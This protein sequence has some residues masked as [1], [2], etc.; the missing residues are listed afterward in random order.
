[1]ETLLGT[2]WHHLPAEKVEELLETSMTKGLDLFTVQER[3]EHFGPNVLSSKKGHGPVVRFLLQFSQPLVI[4]LL[5][6]GIV[7]GFIVEWSDAS[8][9]LAVVLVNAIIGFVQESRAV[10]AIEA[11]ARTMTTTTTVLRSGEVRSLSSE[12]LVPGDIVVLQS[13]DRVPADLRLFQLRELRVDE[14]VLTGESIPLEKDVGV[15]EHSA[16][17]A[18][19]RNMAYASTLVTFGQGRGIVVATGNRT[20]MGRISQLISTVQSL[21]TPLTQRI[22][23]FSRILLFAILG[24]GVLT[25][26]A[27][28]LH[29]ER[30][31]DMFMAAV[32]LT[33]GSVPEG[34]PA[35]VTIILAVGVSR[36]AARK[37]IIRRLPAVET[38]GSTTVICSDKTGT[39]TENQMT[40]MEILAGDSLYTVTGSGYDPAGNVTAGGQAV[41]PDAAPALMECLR[42]GLLC[43]DSR[44]VHSGDR[45]SVEGDPT[46]GALIVSAAKGGLRLEAESVTLPR[47]D[48]IPFESEY[49]YMATLHGTGDGPPILYAK[50]SVESVVAR[51]DDCLHSRGDFAALDRAKVRRDAEAMARQ[52]LRV[53]AFARRELP[54]GQTSLSRE[55]LS[56]GLT[57]LGLQGMIDPPRQEAVQAVRACQKAGIQV[58][59]ITGD[60]A[61]TASAIAQKIGLYLNPGTCSPDCHVLTAKDLAEISDT[62]L[63]QTVHDTEVFARV[64]P[65]QKLRLVRALQSR[66]EIVAMTGDGVNDA[67]ALKQADIGV[68]MGITGTEVA[69]ESADMILTDDNFASIEAAVEE[70]RCVFD[71]LTKFIAWALPTNIGQGLVILTAVLAGVPL[72]ILPVQSL[73]INMTTAGSLGLMLAFEPKEGGIMERPPRDPGS[74]ILSRDLLLQVLLVGFILLCSAFGLFELEEWSGAS[75]AEARTVSVNVFAAVSS[76]Y[77]LNCRSL[78]RPSFRVNPFRNAW[79]LLGIVLM[80][81]VQVA[82]THVPF[83]NVFFHSAPI[84]LEAWGKIIACAVIAHLLV[85]LHKWFFRRR[86]QAAAQISQRAP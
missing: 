63:V 22:A 33:V 32:A 46:E 74:P 12:E 71:N 13:G 61:L 70:G 7:T 39:L 25:F 60:H 62:Q 21:E 49:Q 67:P 1:M 79:I 51:C 75:H 76:V 36:M 30:V 27:G 73:W 48:T 43:N 40:V 59:M 8:V 11:L 31:I 57:F 17:L 69:K 3:Q 52:G 64:S 38:L 77:L 54:K 29:G 23:H 18:D 2:H 68:A 35:A 83:M 55:D 80:A 4:I 10:G 56:S 82:F 24:L 81:G 84:S 45:W 19:R 15:L 53:L 58:K 78:R 65:E 9:I 5:G 41:D 50:G 14:S 85:E 72:P 86:S 6:A 37:V 16:V 34:L 47:L 44:L 42:A 66:G 26:G 28:L 20:E